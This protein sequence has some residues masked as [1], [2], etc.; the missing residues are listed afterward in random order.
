MPQ[1]WAAGSVFHLI[2]AILGFEADAREKHLVID[3]V[4]PRWLRE[5]TVS[6]LHVGRA[7]VDMR[8]W[9]EGDATRH[10]VLNAEGELKIERR[11]HISDNRDARRTDSNT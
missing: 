10:E 9:R 6:K 2:R 5:I 4:P 8:F 11:E 3:P 7:S 1:A